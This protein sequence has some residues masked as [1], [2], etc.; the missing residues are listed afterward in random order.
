MPTF[1]P[2]GRSVAYVWD[3]PDGENHDLYVVSSPG[4]PPR[5]LTSAPEP[6]LSPAWSPGGGEIAFLRGAGGSTGRLML[7]DLASG[8]ERELTWLRAW[9]TPTT[10]N[11]AWSPDGKWLVVL[12]QEQGRKFG[13]PYLYSPATGEMRPAA[14]LPDDAEYIHPNFS[15]DG[16]RLLIVRGDRSI[17]RLPQQDL[18]PD[19]QPSGTPVRISPMTYSLYPSMLASAVVLFQSP[20]SARRRIWRILE[21]GSPPEPLEQLGEGVASFSLSSDGKR[22]AIARRAMDIELA[23]YRLSA[24]GAWQGPAAVAGSLSEKSGPD[25]SPDG[26]QGAFVSNRSGERQIWVAGL[27]EPFVRQL[28][29]TDDISRGPHWLRDGRTIRFGRRKGQERSVFLVETDGEAAPR[30]ELG[31]RYIHHQF[32]DGR[33]TFFFAGVGNRERLYRLSSGATEAPATDGPA[34]HAIIDP[35]SQWIYCINKAGGDSAV[36]MRMPAAGAGPPRCSRTMC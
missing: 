21:P 34:S 11:L 30:F 2:D 26:R 16:R 29:A 17:D 31:D 20:G 28:K 12:H 5:R 8:K 36:L 32:A 10:R 3:G 7:L 1:S 23:Q 35:A 27:E 4:E 14:N 19:Y 13:H 25:V 9:H 18:T 6:D 33:L 24:D 15:P 22:I